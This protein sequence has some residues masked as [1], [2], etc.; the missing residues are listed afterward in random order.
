MLVE[1]AVA[2]PVLRGEDL[3]VPDPP[4]LEVPQLVEVPP[5]W[6]P[7]PVP[8]PGPEPP[9][10][11]AEPADAEPSWPRLFAVLLAEALAGARPLR[12]V[13]PLMSERGGSQLRRLQPL[14]G[15]GPQPKIMR[16]LTSA[17]GPDVIEMTLILA[18]GGRARAVAVRLER[19]V[20]T[21]P[22]PAQPEP[23]Q[24]QTAPPWLCTD[25]EAA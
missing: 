8:S 16:V 11:P 21:Q 6:P 13:L 7:L 17:L 23:A 2:G 14:F 3:A 18:A 24:R 15:G 1:Q 4:D 20:P 12:Q 19:T 5:H 25:V 22:E 9:R 10:G